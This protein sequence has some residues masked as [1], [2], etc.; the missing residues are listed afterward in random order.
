MRRFLPHYDHANIAI[1]TAIDR[2]GEAALA[3]V[4]A[5]RPS[6]ATPSLERLSP[7]HFSPEQFEKMCQSLL[8]N[9]ESYKSPNPQ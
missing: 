6:P 3:Q 7:K 9:A 1:T 5:P 2:A 4:P 8:T